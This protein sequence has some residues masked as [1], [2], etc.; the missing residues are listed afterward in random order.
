VPNVVSLSSDVKAVLKTMVDVEKEFF[1][2]KMAY[3]A[4]RKTLQYVDA[5]FNELSHVKAL[6]IKQ[7]VEF[8][9]LAEKEKLEIVWRS[10]S[11]AATLFA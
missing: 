1:E 9:I 8:T 5:E 11:S 6:Y 10:L 7:L 3:E 4:E 2:K